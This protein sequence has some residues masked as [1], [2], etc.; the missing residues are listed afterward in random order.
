MTNEPSNG[1]KYP[2]YKWMM[3]FEDKLLSAIDKRMVRLAGF[4]ADM[5]TLENKHSKCSNETNQRLER[6]ERLLDQS[7]HFIVHWLGKAAVTIYRVGAI[8]ALWK[9]ATQNPELANAIKEV[10]MK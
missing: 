5:E 10:V 1:D 7:K 6:I 3:E 4:E 2:T 8:Y 9:I